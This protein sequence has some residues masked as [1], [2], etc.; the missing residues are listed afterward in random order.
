M[1]M[2][3]D[4]RL[5][6]FP[7]ELLT[8]IYDVAEGL[9]FPPTSVRNSGTPVTPVNIRGTRETIQIE[10]NEE[11][12]KPDRDKISIGYVFIQPRSD[13]CC[14][15][16]IERIKPVAY[17]RVIHED[18]SDRTLI[19]PDPH[20]EI[21]I[22]SSEDI[23]RAK[24]F[25]TFA[26]AVMVKAES[27]E[28]AETWDTEHGRYGILTYK[29]VGFIHFP[30]EATKERY[31]QERQEAIAAQQA[32][33][34]ARGTE[35][36]I[37]FEGNCKK[38]DRLVEAIEAFIKRELYI[39]THE[40]EIGLHSGRLE[41][42]LGGV[43]RTYDIWATLM[44]W[45]ETPIGRIEVNALN[46]ENYQFRVWRLG[47]DLPDWLNIDFQAVKDFFDALAKHLSKS[48][49]EGTRLAG[50][51]QENIESSS[52][53]YHAPVKSADLSPKRKVFIGLL[54]LLSIALILSLR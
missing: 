26:Y 3:L 25:R 50:V 45:G 34:K 14:R 18:N 9:D 51:S 49:G 23:D 30:N 33:M 36:A 6:I 11:R 16:T 43:P 19:R 52:A 24:W 47:N 54:L 17:M 4:Q 1:P 32:R 44:G 28:S 27:K 10:I 39:P 5:S 37:V 15:L 38:E 41:M 31:V 12:S 8:I 22:L 48:Y 21:T 7:E 46:D 53:V 20:P 40:P 2:I 13:N 35:S 42:F 29:D